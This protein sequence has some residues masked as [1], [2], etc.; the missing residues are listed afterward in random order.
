MAIEREANDAKKRV[1]ESK[2]S[3]RGNT[4]DRSYQLN[5][6]RDWIDD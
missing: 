3:S 1:K 5:E 2:K 6:L 4:K